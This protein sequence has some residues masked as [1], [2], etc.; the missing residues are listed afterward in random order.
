[1]LIMLKKMTFT[2]SFDTI[3]VVNRN[4]KGAIG[5]IRNIQCEQTPNSF[6]GP[7]MGMS[8]TSSLES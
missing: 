6:E 3:D 4:L 2:K 1:M 7:R 8:Q 5:T